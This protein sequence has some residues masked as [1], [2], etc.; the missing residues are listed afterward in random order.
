MF[1]HILGLKKK[2]R[3]LDGGTVN[4]QQ[5]YPS[6]YC[7]DLRTTAGIGR[8]DTNYLLPKGHIG[9]FLLNSMFRETRHAAFQIYTNDYLLSCFAAKFKFWLVSCMSPKHR[10]IP[11]FEIQGQCL[12]YAKWLN[13]IHDC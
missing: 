13:K 8:S 7:S 9:V 6:I 12:P 4:A 11:L 1:I 5:I 3:K 2:K 10:E